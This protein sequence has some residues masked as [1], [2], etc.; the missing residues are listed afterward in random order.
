[1][2]I[3]GLS[4]SGLLEKQYHDISD[5]AAVLCYKPIARGFLELELSDYKE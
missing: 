5:D 4:S 2:T 1:M 3:L